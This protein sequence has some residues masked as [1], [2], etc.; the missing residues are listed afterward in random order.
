[1]FSALGD[2]HLMAEGELTSRVAGH[3][4]SFAGSPAKEHLSLLVCSSST[5]EVLYCTSN[6]HSAF[7]GC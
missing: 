4:S 6:P 2:P 1:M 5:L 7:G 3:L